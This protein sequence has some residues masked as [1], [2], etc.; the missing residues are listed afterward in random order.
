MKGRIS[1]RVERASLLPEIRKECT[2]CLLTIGDIVLLYEQDHLR[3]LWRLA[4][5]D[6]LL[7]GADGQ[8][9]EAMV[10][11]HNKGIDCH[12]WAS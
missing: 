2:I 11:V 9:R 6:Q 10:R 1:H 8:V 12:C 5:I 7:S 3:G 4:V